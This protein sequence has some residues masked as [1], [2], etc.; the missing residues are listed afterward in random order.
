MD[1]APAAQTG[2]LVEAGLCPGFV[3]EIIVE[4]YVDG[5]GEAREEDD[6]QEL[7]GDVAI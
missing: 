1:Q 3:K 2:G 4:D 6:E 5:E 7:Q